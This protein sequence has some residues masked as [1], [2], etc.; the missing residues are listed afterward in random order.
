MNH[1]FSM[2]FGADEI[3]AIKHLQVGFEFY[4]HKFGEHHF[5]LET[6]LKLMAFMRSHTTPVNL[7]RS[8]EHER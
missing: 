1:Y 2:S 6:D 3:C 7:A 5:L 4:R 8:T